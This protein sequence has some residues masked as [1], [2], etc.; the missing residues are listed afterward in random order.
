MGMVVRTSTRRAPLS[1]APSP[2]PKAK[3]YAVYF[4]CSALALLLGSMVPAID[5]ALEHE[6]RETMVTLA[7][8]LPPPAADVVDAGGAVAWQTVAIE[9]G[10]TLGSLFADLGIS[11]NVM[12]RVLEVPEARQLATRLQPG[13]E[14]AFDI[15]PDGSL[16][17]LR[18]DQDESRRIELAVLPDG[19]EREVIE[20]PT[21]RRMMVAAGEIRSS[22]F[23][24]G[25]RAG[26]GFGVMNEM[27]R[28]LQYDIDFAQDLREGDR[29]EIVYEEI[30]REGQR[31]RDGGM[32]AVR[33]VNRGRETTA[34]RFE[35]EGRAGFFDPSG[36]PLERSFLRT[37]IE[38]ARVT[39]GFGTRRHPVLNRIRMH[40][41]VD[42]A[43]PIGTPIFAAGAGRVSFAGW[44]GGFGRTVILDHGNGI[45]T[46]YAHMS[47][48]GR[49]RVGQRVAQGT[50]IG[51]VGMSGLATGPHLH[52]EFRVRG[53]HK[54]PL[55][56]TL[57]KPEPLAG[58]QLAE[59]RRATA[60][61]LA[62]L[63]RLGATTFAQ[64]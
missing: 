54:D 62:N 18:F 38:F 52:Y 9:R 25:A 45:T 43:A 12:H 49:Y 61:A 57:P 23:A 27:V 8:A 64:R 3:P 37:P 30:W 63:E 42:Y 55:K 20:R 32:L 15:G 10:Q 11:A 2:A 1:H 24:D 19:V 40:R 17:G 48:L 31:L 47:R 58:P 39:S 7:I 35:R 34:L 28:A 21:E 36:R 44:Q 6:P 51:Y 59:F 26:L 29:F 5:Q 60:P 22:L 16:R 4:L 53:V 41:G 14:L 46:L 13:S 56:V 33:F 50:T